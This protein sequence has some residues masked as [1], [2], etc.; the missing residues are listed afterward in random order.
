MKSHKYIDKANYG[1]DASQ[2]AVS[3]EEDEIQRLREQRYGNKI[4]QLVDFNQAFELVKS[5]VEDKFKM[6]REIGRAHV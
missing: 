3:N 1:S 4:L 6:Q 2:G 5:A